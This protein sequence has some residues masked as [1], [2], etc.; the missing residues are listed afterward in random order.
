MKRVFLFS[1]IFALLSF[2]F[3]YIFSLKLEQ[4]RQAQVAGKLKTFY[5]KMLRNEVSK[6]LLLAMTLSQNQ[7][8]KEALIEIDE[9]RGHELLANTLEYLKRYSAIEEIRA[10]IIAK[11]LTIFARSWDKEFAGMPI[12]GFRK[13]LSSF[14]I[15]HP[16]AGVETGR[17]L[18]IKATAPIKDGYKIIG[19]L[20][21]IS[22]FEPLAKRLR[23]DGIELFVLMDDRYLD[24]A[25]LMRENPTIQGF[26]V[27]NRNY[28]AVLLDRL[29]RID[30]SHL[31]R[32]GFIA[33]GEY[34]FVSIPM[35]N[36]KGEKI[37]LYVLAMSDKRLKELERLQENLSF[38]I[39][40]EKNEF[41]D[42]I[43]LWQ[44]PEA[45]FNS[46]YDRSVLEF[47]AKVKDPQL[48]RSFEVEAREIL[49]EY[50]KEE[51]IDIILD[52]YHSQ[53]KRGAIE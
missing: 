32:E 39:Q 8:L 18:T 40:F 48:K 9:E 10:Q 7:A 35:Q 16:K 27:S 43:N 22:F 2:V 42:L 33:E 5:Q 26:V 45:A 11:D 24:V 52:K 6:A 53:K 20:E 12:E 23:N 36:S 28:N 51:L 31:A 13:D 14:K 34:F 19:Y 25:T 15:S 30:L 21:I 46:V 37:G 29:K 4:N 49:R 47:L 1:I 41:Y 38:F 50:E 17:L 3:F 44:R